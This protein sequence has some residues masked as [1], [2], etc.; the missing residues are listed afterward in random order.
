MPTSVR[1]SLTRFGPVEPTPPRIHAAACALVE[2]EQGE[3]GPEGQHRAND[4]PWSVWPFEATDERGQ[5][6]WQL[7]LL[8]DSLAERVSTNLKK[9]VR[10]GSVT[11]EVDDVGFRTIPY[12]ELV[13]G[14]SS[15][16]F[17]VE[18]ASPTAF[19]RGDR[20]LPL[21]DPDA[22]I[23]GLAR[24]WNHW[25]PESDHLAGDRV[26]NLRASVAVSKAAIETTE[27][28]AGEGRIRTGFVG[29]VRFVV[30]KSAG[31]QTRHDFAALC[32]FSEFAGSGVN[33]RRGLGVT[34]PKNEGHRDRQVA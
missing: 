26:R 8:D 20:E 19:K 28:E 33:V 9:P 5:W 13:S 34:L 24:R 16:S 1:I 22:F 2:T 21:P 15:S 4:K 32:R 3:R 11:L 25:A 18:F 7:N 14:P 6:L 31:E 23:G 12:S 29:S 30:M 17:D 10:I 27:Y